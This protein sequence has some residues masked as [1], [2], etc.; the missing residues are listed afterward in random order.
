M[1][2]TVL[3]S[4]PMARRSARGRLLSP[5]LFVLVLVLGGLIGLLYLTQ[6]SG[7]ATTGYDIKRLEVEREQWLAQNEQLRLQI[8]E[9]QSI[10]H[11]EQAARLRLHMQPP[12][13]ILFVPLRPM[14]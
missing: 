9:L 6:T 12:K 3:R 11:I 14:R 10:K 8:A 7:I 5:S 4:I 1:T 2:T 13:E